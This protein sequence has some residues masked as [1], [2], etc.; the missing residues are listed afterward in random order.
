MKLIRQTV[1]KNDENF[2][3]LL[4]RNCVL[5]DFQYC[6]FCACCH[7]TS[8]MFREERNDSIS[9][10]LSMSTPSPL[11]ENWSGWQVHAHNLRAVDQSGDQL[12]IYAHVK[13]AHTHTDFLRSPPY[14]YLC[15]DWF[16]ACIRL[17][18]WFSWS[19][20]PRGP[21]CAPL[22]SNWNCSDCWSHLNANWLGAWTRAIVGW[23]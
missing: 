14:L 17:I 2:T 1:R 21:C 19:I 10:L 23:C 7:T 11:C 6:Y 12:R 3:A 22:R 9:F 13:Y 16:F 8:K 20:L 18:T 5:C 4:C 15:S